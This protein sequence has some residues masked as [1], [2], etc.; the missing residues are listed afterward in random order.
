MSS[1][2]QTNRSSPCIQ[3]MGMT[4]PNPPQPTPDRHPPPP[5]Y[6]SIPFSSSKLGI[7]IAST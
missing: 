5:Q 7:D 4:A 1:E 6:E 2:N 3:Q